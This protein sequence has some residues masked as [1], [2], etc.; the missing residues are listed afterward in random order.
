MLARRRGGEPVNEKQKPGR[1]LQ[2]VEARTLQV[3]PSLQATTAE[4]VTTITQAQATNT[5]QAY[6]YDLAAWKAWCARHDVDADELHPVAIVAYLQSCLD[7]DR[8]PGAPRGLS[9]ATVR[10]RAAALA[11]ESRRR[12]PDRPS[13]RAHPAVKA[14]LSGAQVR[15]GAQQAREK[16]RGERRTAARALLPEEVQRMAD[17]CDGTLAGLRDRALLLVGFT[18][19]LRRSELA[20]L[21]LEDVTT[22]DD[23]DA[24]EGVVLRLRRTKAKPEGREVDLPRLGSRYCP[25]AALNAYLDKARLHGASGPVFRGLTKHGTLRAS[26]ITGDTV[27]A[28]VQKRAK[29]AGVDAARL[30]AHSLRRGCLTAAAR[31]GAPAYALQDHAGHR[32]GNTTA[33]YLQKPYRFTVARAAWSS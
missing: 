18:G 7:E 26:G 5:Q 4:A 16:Q 10:R 6:A 23:V 28:V 24:S 13:P 31:N 19:A 9:L 33:T 15:Y 14:L 32:D 3:V 12:Y 1:T 22:P 27:N 25:V 8:G 11:H 17:A 21:H 29:A 20:G 2:V 30:S